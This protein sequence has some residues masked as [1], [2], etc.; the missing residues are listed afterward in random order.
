MTTTKRFLTKITELDGRFSTWREKDEKNTANYDDAQEQAEADYE[1]ALNQLI[2]ER[3]IMDAKHT[4]ARDRILETYNDKLSASKKRQTDTLSSIESSKRQAQENAEAFKRRK[5]E[6][7]NA[8][9]RRTQ[10]NVQTDYDMLTK[11]ETLAKL[12]PLPYNK[13]ETSGRSKPDFKALVSLLDRA[14]K[15]LPTGLLA[16]SVLFIELAVLFLITPAAAVVF[17]TSRVAPALISAVL[18]VICGVVFALLV[19]KRKDAGTALGKGIA[20]ARSYLAKIT[21]EGSAYLAKVMEESSANCAKVIEKSMSTAENER[22]AANK[23]WGAETAEA[24]REKTAET[25]RVEE[26]IAGEIAVFEKER[27]ARMRQID[28]E[29]EEADRQIEQQKANSIAALDREFDA[30]M[31]DLRQT[32]ENLTAAFEAFGASP[33]WAGDIAPARQYPDEIMF[34][35]LEVS[36]PSLPVSKTAEEFR[37]SG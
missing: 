10:D 3:D 23:A 27:E 26:K 7:V 18:G 21:E 25:Q 13:S 36:T 28:E 16:L 35:S 2:T 31:K 1:K 32:N 9:E 8:D 12:K 11:I 24:D 5:R 14:I 15:P 20:S 37:K 29:K 6:E 17:E 19:V 4:G 34:G 33:I 22:A 30:V